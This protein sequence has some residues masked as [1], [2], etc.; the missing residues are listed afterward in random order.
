MALL[1]KLE[2][3]FEVNVP[4][5]QFH[6]VYSCRPHHVSIMSPERIQGVELHEGEWGKEGSVICWNYTHDGSLKIAKEIIEV[7]DDVNLSTTFKVIG[8]DLLKDYKSF[9][10]I[11]QATQKGDGSLVHWTLEYEK[12]HENT[13]APNT[14][15]DFVVH[16]SK[17]ISA[18]LKQ[19]QAN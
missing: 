10:F 8:G 3:S 6:N 13:P 18:H 14:L 1:K 5:N 16:C 15:M 2:A 4:A 12:V 11:V 9:K 19:A 7:I 17:D